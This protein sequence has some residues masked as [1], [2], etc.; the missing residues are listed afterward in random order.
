MV[1]VE[2]IVIGKRRFLEQRAPGGDEEDLEP[3]MAHLNHFDINPIFM[4]SA[5]R[6]STFAGS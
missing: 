5:G 4:F 1:D 3:E 6:C 2:R